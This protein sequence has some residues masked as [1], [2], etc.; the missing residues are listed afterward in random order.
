M[1]DIDYVNHPPHYQGNPEGIECIQ[2][3][4][5]MN[6]NVGNAVKYLWRVD[7]KDDPIENLEKAKW[8]IDDEIKR[9]SM[10]TS[11]SP[12]ARVRDAMGDIWTLKGDHLWSIFWP[13]GESAVFRDLT[14]EEI[15]AV[16]GPLTQIE[17][18]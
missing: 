9:R 1:T 16:F 11:A 12:G 15:E 7:S 17:N 18:G 3:T 6:F 4:R 2:V 14:Y 10:D 13:D 5:W 8:Y